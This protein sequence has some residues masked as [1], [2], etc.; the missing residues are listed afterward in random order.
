MNW[1]LRRLAGL[2]PA[3][4]EVRTMDCGCPDDGRPVSSCIYCWFRHCGDHPADHDCPTC[5][6]C[7][8]RHGRPLHNRVGGRLVEVVNVEP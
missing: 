2:T 6:G 4:P 5:P 8:I 7:G 1:M 3:L